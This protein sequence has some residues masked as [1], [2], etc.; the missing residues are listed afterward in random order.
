MESP[1]EKAARAEFSEDGARLGMSLCP[2]D[3]LPRRRRNE[4]C[5]A[6][7]ALGAVNFLAYTVSYAALGGDAHN[8][9]RELIEKSDGTVQAV[10]FVRGHFIRSLTGQERAVSRGMWV[11]SYLHSISVLLTSAAMIISMLVL[12]R[13]HIIATMRGGLVSGLTFVTVFGT[14]VM[15]VTVAA[16]ALFTWDFV[17]QLGDSMPAA[18]SQSMAPLSER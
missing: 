16:V 8:G 3:R 17:A 9:H 5:I 13:P 7:I 1:A 15:L 2:V 14:I 18:P 10:Y 6:V 11:Y 12:A 4:I